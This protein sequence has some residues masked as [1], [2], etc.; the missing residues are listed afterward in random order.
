MEAISE[1]LGLEK[2]CIEKAQRM[3]DHDPSSRRGLRLTSPK[4]Q[5]M[6]RRKPIPNM[7]IINIR[8]QIQVQIPFYF[9]N[10]NDIWEVFDMIYVLITRSLEISRYLATIVT[11]ACY[12]EQLL[13]TI[14][15]GSPCQLSIVHHQMLWSSQQMCCLMKNIH[16]W[17]RVSHTENTM[18]TFGAKGFNLP[19]A[20][21][22]LDLWAHG[23]WE[24]LLCFQMPS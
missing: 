24:Q 15:R 19:A 8:D 12:I 20:L 6:G 21:I 4:K 16:W 9:L 18:M 3:G 13:T 7:F 11:R 1:S 17:T 10:C 22:S 14:A 5:E 2:D 23:C